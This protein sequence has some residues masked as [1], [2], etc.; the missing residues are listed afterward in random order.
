MHFT[1]SKSSPYSMLILFTKTTEVIETFLKNPCGRISNQFARMQI[2]HIN[3]H[4]CKLYIICKQFSCVLELS[5]YDYSIS[6]FQLFP[7]FTISK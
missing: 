4:V 2:L 6:L 3:V 5:L 1:G 7:Y